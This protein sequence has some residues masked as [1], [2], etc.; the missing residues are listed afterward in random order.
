[1]EA[2]SSLDK[3]NTKTTTKTL[4]S[5]TTTLTTTILPTTYL[6]TPDELLDW[7]MLVVNQLKW[8]LLQSTPF[9]FFDQILVRS[10]VLEALREDFAHC[11]HKM[12]RG[13]ENFLLKKISRI[14]L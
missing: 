5:T 2:D 12:Q 6:I 11:L 1:M 13:G 14:S 8:N 3:E 9:E 7:E 10:P 4:I